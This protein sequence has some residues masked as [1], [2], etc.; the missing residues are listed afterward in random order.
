MLLRYWNPVRVG[1]E[2]LDDYWCYDSELVFCFVLAF[3]VWY[4]LYYYYILYII[5]HTYTYIILY[6]TFLLPYLLSSFIISSQSSNPS[7][8][9]FLPNIHSICVG[10][11]YSGGDSLDDKLTPHVLSEWMVEVCRFEV[12]ASW[13]GLFEIWLV[14]GSSLCFGGSPVWD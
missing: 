5:I 8:S 2:L 11:L 14:S 4:I 12:Y 3:D 10:C 6:S 13:I 9:F 7:F 1:F